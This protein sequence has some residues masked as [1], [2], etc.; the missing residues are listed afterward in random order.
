MLGWTRRG[1][2]ASER[3]VVV[4][5]ECS[6]GKTYMSYTKDERA[7][8]GGGNNGRQQQA[9]ERARERL[10]VVWGA[11]VSSVSLL[12]RGINCRCCRQ[13]SRRYS[14]S[15][16]I[17]Q[18]SASSAGGDVVAGA[19]AELSG[20]LEEANPSRSCPAR[21]SLLAYSSARRLNLPP[22]A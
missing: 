22:F 14:G 20:G 13:Y 7:G 4:V 6:A 5:V 3:A 1:V 11:V 21:R 15:R 10:L 2:G 18:W 17:N 19:V 12:E 16:K 9:G 8:V